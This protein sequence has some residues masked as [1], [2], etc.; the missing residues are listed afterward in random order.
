MQ[1]PGS[2]IRVDNLESDYFSGHT[3]SAYMPP[4]QTSA[5][6][7]TGHT[8]ATYRPFRP[9]NV[10]PPPFPEFVDWTSAQEPSRREKRSP[11]KTEQ[12]L[13]ERESISGPD[14]LYAKLSSKN[15]ASKYRRLVEVEK[16]AHEG[17]LRER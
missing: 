6:Y 17:I 2:A 8:A 11:S 1:Y 10:E 7:V 5:T 15:Y 4:A 3:S 13:Y 12:P 9:S 14:P 16:T